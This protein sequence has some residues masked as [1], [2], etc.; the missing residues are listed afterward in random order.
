M[1]F[2]SLFSGWRRPHSDAGVAGS[3]PQAATPPRPFPTPPTAA[4]FPLHSVDDML[5]AHNGLVRRIKLAYGVDDETFSDDLMT[6]MRRYASYVNLLPATPDNYFHGAG[7]LFRLGLEVAFYALQATDGQIF[8]GRA[9][10]TVRRQLEPRWRQATF[11]AGLCSELHR[12][13]SH[14]RVCDASGNE[15]PAYLAPLTDW[16]RAQHSERFFVRWLPD[17]HELRT[18]GVLA[19][20]H[21]VSTDTLHHLSQ[22]NTV[23]VPHM[24]ASIGGM[25]IYPEH[26]ML[27]QLVRHAAALVIERDLQANA[28]RDGKRQTGAHLTRFILEAM[29]RLVISHRAWTP[30]TEKS[31]VWHGQD[32]VYLVW[33]HAAADVISLLDADRLPG[34]PKSAASMLDILRDAGVITAREPG[35]LVWPI[36]PP[37]TNSPIDAIKFT[38]SASLLAPLAGASVPLPFPLAAPRTAMSAAATGRGREDGQR[39]HPPTAEQTGHVLRLQPPLAPAAAPAEADT[40]SPENP[41]RSHASSAAAPAFRFQGPLRLNPS[42]RTALTDIVATLN[43][44][45]A[46][47]CCS[48]PTGLFIPLA[49]LERRQLDTATAIRAL[50]DLTML[51]P[52][53]PGNNKIICHAIGGTNM[54]GI[55]IAPQYICGLRPSENA[56]VTTLPGNDDARAPL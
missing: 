10:I 12:T 51:A 34:M 52:Y 35:Q 42:L 14:L 3:A 4:G 16:M 41:E 15:W 33:P 11:I 21:I 9:T 7:G 47:A 46:P 19:L 25:P 48:I 5:A 43:G 27:D 36:Y 2:G 31:R 45:G 26:N 49:E 56:I 55:V 22:G 50:S 38:S 28:D 40:A 8:S 37:E 24:I 32:G 30:N 17:A 1:V 53:S 13:L 44:P 18:L 29:H 39:A 23:V 6:V 54:S 20:P